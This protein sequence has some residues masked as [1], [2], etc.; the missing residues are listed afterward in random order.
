MMKI[1]FAELKPDFKKVARED[2]T[3][4]IVELSEINQGDLIIFN[5]IYDIQKDFFCELTGKNKNGIRSIVGEM[6]GSSYVSDEN[7]IILEK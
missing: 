4:Y 2:L 5:T 1:P 6:F 7:Y 3:Y